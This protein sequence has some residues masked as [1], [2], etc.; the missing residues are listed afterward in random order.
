M[1]EIEEAV[2]ETVVPEITETQEKPEATKTDTEAST[3]D[4]AGF[5]KAIN[6]KHFQY[7]EQK[8]RAD[9]LAA[10][11]ERLKELTLPAKPSIP[12]IPDPYADNFDEL[13]G[14]RD[15]AIQEVA[16]YNANAAAQQQFAQQQQQL[17]QQQEQNR[18]NQS[19]ATYAGRAEKLGVSAEELQVAGNTVAAY[20]I[21]DELAL[22]VLA[23]EQGP[24]ITTYLARNPAELEKLRDMPAI[25]AGI[26][27]A[28]NIKDKI[29][30]TSGISNAPDPADSL[31]GG[32]TAPKDD[33]P[34][35]VKYE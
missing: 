1:S 20:G 18:L 32:G 7:K 17:S 14:N 12:Q 26:Y 2:V 11:V 22:H 29:K 23:D 10:E 27:I 16:Q 28:T 4:P 21:S 33:G 15:K 6:R 24:Q 8:R 31:S 34:A 9:E 13:M 5:T 30:A 25:Q 35:G 3:D 19:V